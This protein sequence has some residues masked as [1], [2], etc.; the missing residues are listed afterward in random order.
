MTSVNQVNPA[1][2][3]AQGKPCQCFTDRRTAPVVPITFLVLNANAGA[4]G[5]ES[6]ERSR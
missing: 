6:E 2:V 5:I 3:K 1:A 4:A